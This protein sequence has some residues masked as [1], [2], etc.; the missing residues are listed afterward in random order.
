MT[1]Q[2]T[3]GRPLDTQTK[4]NDWFHEIENCCLTNGAKEGDDV[5]LGDAY[6][7]KY[8]SISEVASGKLLDAIQSRRWRHLIM[9]GDGD[10]LN[11]HGEIEL[12]DSQEPIALHTGRGKDGFYAAFKIAEQLKNKYNV[13][14]LKSRS[15]C[16]VALLLHNDQEDLIIPYPPNATS[17]ENYQ[18]FSVDSVLEVLQPMARDFLESGSDNVKNVNQFATIASVNVN[19]FIGDNIKNVKMQEPLGS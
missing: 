12:D 10:K 15:L 8:L 3:V 1:I 11:V 4:L 7:V 16:F 19:N 9:T 18:V 2:L 14:I 6:E 5:S 17:L 13:S